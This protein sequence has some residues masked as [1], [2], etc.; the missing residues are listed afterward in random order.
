MAELPS[1]VA[2]VLREAGSGRVSPAR[3]SPPRSS[4]WKGEVGHNGATIEAFPAATEAL[5]EFAGSTSCRT[6][7]V[8]TFAAVPSRSIPTLVAATTETLADLGRVLNTVLFPIGMEGDHES[9]LAIDESGRVFA[10]DHAGL[11]GPG[12]SVAAA[13]TTL[14]TGMQPPRLKEQG[15][16]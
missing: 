13:L 8:A 14:V 9:V 4:S 12:G 1:D 15:N 6:V 11:W 5:R 7:L 10:L 3:S 2:Q 16:W